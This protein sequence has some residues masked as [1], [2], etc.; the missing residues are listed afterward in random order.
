MKFLIFSGSLLIICS[1][2]FAAPNA[3]VHSALSVLEQMRALSENE[4]IVQVSGTTC[5]GKGEETSGMNKICYYDC[6][7]SAAA[8]TIS[9]T[10]LCPLTIKN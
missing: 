5:F 4:G 1:A 8:I 10:S 2:A 6:L 3:S 7:G 9:S